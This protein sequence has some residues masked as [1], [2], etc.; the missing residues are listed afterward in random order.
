M[1]GY[2]EVFRDVHVWMCEPLCIFRGKFRKKK[3]MMLLF[4]MNKILQAKGAEDRRQN[5]IVQVKYLTGL[6]E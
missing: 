4:E 6:E 2:L 5:E 3:G 1:D